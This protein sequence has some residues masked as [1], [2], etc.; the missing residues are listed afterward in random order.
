MC[1]SSSALNVILT[2]GFSCQSLSIFIG[3][4]RAYN[5]INLI[6]IVRSRVENNPIK[7]H[8]NIGVREREGERE[9]ERMRERKKGKRDEH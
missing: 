3:N 6:A 8:K 7:L 4:N 5:P 9:R 1:V 2:S